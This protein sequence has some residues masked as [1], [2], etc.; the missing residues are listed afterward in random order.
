M[1]VQWRLS[2]QQLL[3]RQ[4]PAGNPAAATAWATMANNLVNQAITPQVQAFRLDPASAGRILDVTF[5][6]NTRQ[7][8]AASLQQ[9]V[10]VQSSFAVRNTTFADVC[11]P[12]PTG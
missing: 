2:S 11:T 10:R 1:C 6:V 7:G 9:T 8:S 5:L 12:V 4:W 3:R